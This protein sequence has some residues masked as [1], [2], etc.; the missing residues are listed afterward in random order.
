METP[1]RQQRVQVISRTTVLEAAS[2]AADSGG[3]KCGD[4]VAANH[5]AR[6]DA[7]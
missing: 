1:S 6:E 3:A 2:G 7:S 4:S 5:C